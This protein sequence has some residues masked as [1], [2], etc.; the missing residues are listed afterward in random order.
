MN[1]AGEGEGGARNP[2]TGE[3][4]LGDPKEQSF[5]TGENEAGVTGIMLRSMAEHQAPSGETRCD[6]PSGPYEPASL[7]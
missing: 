6:L 4:G 7:H 2:P 1:Q 5:G 3:R